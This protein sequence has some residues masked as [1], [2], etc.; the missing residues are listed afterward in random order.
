KH[1]L[2]FFGACWLIGETAS[3]PESANADAPNASA[4]A[5]ATQRIDQP[6]PRLSLIVIPAVCVF[7]RVKT[8]TK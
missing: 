7:F 3:L 1:F 5:T 6:L 2:L 4:M 8:T